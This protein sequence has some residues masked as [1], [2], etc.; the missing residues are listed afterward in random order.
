[1]LSGSANTQGNPPRITL[2]WTYSQNG[3][4]PATGFRIVRT[5]GNVTAIIA[6]INNVNTLTYI[7]TTV[8]AASAYSYRV[9]AFNAGGASLPSN[10][11]ALSTPSASA[12][13]L[14]TPTGLQAIPALIAVNSVTLSWN[15]AAGATKYIVERSTSLN[16]TYTLVGQPTTPTLRVTG[17]TTKT[18]YYF[19]VSAS[20]GNAAAQSVATTPIGVTTK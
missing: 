15:S 20:N 8:A 1:V 10:L 13:R 19:R 2:T 16:G 5:A 4:N 14:P 3:A 9:V 7:N 17:L 18:L 12:N 6:V 11:V